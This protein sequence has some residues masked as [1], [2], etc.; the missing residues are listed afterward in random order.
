[1]SM[2]ARKVDRTRF[3]FDFYCIIEGGAYQEEIERLGFKV[4]VMPA[5]NHR[6][7]ITYDLREILRLAGY[8]R[9]GQYDIVHTHLFRADVIGRLAARM[10]G[11]RLMVKTL[12]NMGRWKTRQDVALDRILNRGTQKIICVS[13]YQRQEAIAQEK[14]PPD[15]V[16]TIPFGVDVNRFRVNVERGNL[17]RSFGLDASRPVVGTVGRLIEEKGHTYLVQAL[18]RILE[19]HPSAQFLIV[20]D[21]HLR[22]SLVSAVDKLGF[23]G[24]VRFAGLRPDVAELLSVMDVF[25]FPSISEGLPIAV[26]EAMAARRA[27][28]C[29]SIPQVSGVIVDGRTGLYFRPHDSV[30]LADALD[31]LLSDPALRERLAADAFEWVRENYSEQQMVRSI[32][33]IYTELLPARLH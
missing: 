26:I 30:T 21:G 24:V 6:R 13:E 33:A 17:L 4:V 16:V 5:Y 2:M 7:L 10:A 1:M 11:R 20:G 31:R 15:K 3:E 22:E 28:A 19:R 29:S 14:L 9:R 32:E 18:P 23:S 8:L 12:Y 27:I 25:V